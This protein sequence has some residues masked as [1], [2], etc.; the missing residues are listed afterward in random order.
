MSTDLDDQLAAYGAWLNQTTGADLTRSDSS[1]DGTSGDRAAD[2]PGWAKLWLRVA[3][4]LVVAAGIGGLVVSQRSGET[5]PAVQYSQP[6]DP[7]AHLYV[8]PTDPDGLDLANG[9]SYTA[10]PNESTIAPEG[11][12]IVIGTQSEGGF[13]DLIVA[14]VL[15]AL[16]AGFAGSEWI[17][18]DTET[19][20]AFVSTGLVPNSAVAQQRGDR[21]LMLSGATGDQDLINALSHVEV[22]L[23]GTPTIQDGQ[24]VVIEEINHDPNRASYSTSYDITDPTSGITYSVE[25]A[26]FPSA[27]ILGTYT[28]NPITLT[29]VSGTEAWVLTRD[30]DPAAGTS[31]GIVWRATP[32][33]VIAI[34][35]AAPVQDVRAMAERLQ[36]V[37]EDEW[38]AALPGASIQN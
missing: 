21:W 13:S 9:E 18:T 30:D 17:Q 7:A 23:S 34:G 14:S 4:V 37:S 24:R 29:T 1:L 32:N 38:R 20:P 33:R 11:P 3:A 12:M 2:G 35:A 22:D 28:P 26:T 36:Q 10:R 16:P 25:T 6:L 8:L 19:G 5:P 31:I 27:T 15:D